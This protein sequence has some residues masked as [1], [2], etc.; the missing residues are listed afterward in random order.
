MPHWGVCDL[1]HW[2]ATQQIIACTQFVPGPRPAPLPPVFAVRCLIDLLVAL[3]PGKCL[4][5]PAD[6]LGL[7]ID[8]G[9]VVPV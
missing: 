3:L 7:Q 9:N 4:A 1:V 8:D 2:K 5:K 6:D